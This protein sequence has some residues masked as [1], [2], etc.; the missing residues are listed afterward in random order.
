[1]HLIDEVEERDINLYSKTYNYLPAKKSLKISPV[2][3]PLQEDI[4]VEIS[5]PMGK[6]VEI[7]DGVSTIK[8]G[9]NNKYYRIKYKNYSEVPSSYIV[10]SNEDT[11]I[12][13]TVTN[14]DAFVVLEKS[15]HIDYDSQVIVKLPRSK[16]YESF[17]IVITRIY[18]GYSYSIFKGNADYTPK[19]DGSEVDYITIDRS[20]K[21]NMTISNPYLRDENNKGDRNDDDDVY[22]LLFS[23]DDPEMIQKEVFLTF[24]DIKEYEKI[25]IGT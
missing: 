24:N 1:V 12:S 7:S 18:H 15:A 4:N 16:K 20:H 19:L 5:T 13:I 23:I 6:E 21:I 9:S 8:I 22:Y 17:N 3:N 11:V 14:T 25:D 2:L 10:L